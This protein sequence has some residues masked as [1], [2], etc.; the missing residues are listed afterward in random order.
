MGGGNTLAENQVGRPLPEDCVFALDIGT[1]SVIGI[2]GRQRDQLFEVLGAELLEHPQRAM[3]DGQIED[4]RQVAQVAGQVKQAL[5]Q[6]L[7]FQLS[8]VNVAAA[9]RALKS[10]RAQFEMELSAEPITPRQIYDLEMGAITIIREKVSSQTDEPLSYYCVGHSVV[11]YYLDDYPFSTIVGHKC[12]VARVD[13][14]ATFLPAA[15][16]DSLCAAMALIG[17]EIAHL[18]LEPIA[19]MNAVIPAELRLLNL[20]LV[21]IGAGTSD[22]AISENGTVAAYTMAT[23]AGDEITEELIRKYLVD[24]QT[25]ERMK[26]DAAAGKQTILYQDI[27]GFEYSIVLDDI[28]EALRP[29]VETLSKVICEK[30][31]EANTRPPAAVFLVGGGSLVPLLCECVAEGLGLERNKVAVGG[32]NFIRRVAAGADTVSGPEF[33]TPLGI[34]LTAVVEGAQHGFYLFINGKKT[35]LFRND[36]VTV[37]DAL[38]LCGYQY[39]QLMGHNGRSVNYL[40]NGEK[41]IMRAGRLTPAVIRVN[42]VETN[43]TELLNNEDH[44]DV[45]PAQ[46]GEDAFLTLTMLNIDPFEAT[47]YLNQVPLSFGRRVQI[48]DV[49][50]E[51]GQQILDHD[52]IVTDEILTLGDLCAQLGVVGELLLLG[53]EHRS[54]DTVLQDGDR[55]E[56]ITPIRNEVL[57]PDAAQEPT[58]ALSTQEPPTVRDTQANISQEATQNVLPVD[59]PVERQTAVPM[60]QSAAPLQQPTAPMQQPTAPMQEPTT[61]MQQPA[62]PAQESVPAMQPPQQTVTAA[63]PQSA[64]STAPEPTKQSS[65]QQKLEQAWQSEPE[66]AATAPSEP[67]SGAQSSWANKIAQAWAAPEPTPQPDPA[68]QTEPSAPVR[69]IRPGVKITLNG[70]SVLLDPKPQG[71]YQFLDMLNLV[72]IDPTKPQG[73]IVLQLNGRQASYLDDIRSGDTVD[74][75]WE[76]V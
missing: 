19:A 61:P 35:R 49:P 6:R 36:H 20:A 3:I 7:G 40:L 2:V 46:D 26:H 52:V 45:T 34:A 71:S 8:R 17:C 12:A 33:A 28:L 68:P 9:G 14:I 67:D 1:R 25:A 74:I 47:V 16:V 11:R 60:Q 32:N 54:M 59:A 38:L 23:V 44:V 13:V 64:P 30:I 37:M 72:D 62:I 63:A 41:Q 50:A 75:Y 22:I 18:T 4:I 65:W 24:F 48:N 73:N 56:A 5:E 21:D 66:P 58:P 10:D 69:S 42:G 27:L 76:S 70:E 39:H 51:T 55:L 29:A 31:L 53:G 57:R 15:V 43:L